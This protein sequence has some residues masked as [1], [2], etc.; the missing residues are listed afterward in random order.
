MGPI[1]TAN[2]QMEQSIPRQEEVVAAHLIVKA[3][4]SGD[5]VHYDLVKQTGQNGLPNAPTF[6]RE[7]HPHTEGYQFQPEN[8]VV[9]NKETSA[10]PADHAQGN[11]GSWGDPKPL[12]GLPD[13]VQSYAGDGTQWLAEQHMPMDDDTL[14]AQTSTS[15]QHQHQEAG[16]Q[17]QQTHQASPDQSSILL[18]RQS[19]DESMLPKPLSWKKGDEH[20]PEIAL[21]QAKQDFAQW[22]SGAHAHP[23]YVEHMQQLAA[24]AQE[25]AWPNTGD[26]SGAGMHPQDKELQQQAA[27]DPEA[28]HLNA[29]NQEVSDTRHVAEHQASKSSTAVST[30]RHQGYQDSNGVNTRSLGNPLQQLAGLNAGTAAGVYKGYIGSNGKGDEIDQLQQQVV[31]NSGMPAKTYV[32]YKDG[33]GFAYVDQ[34]PVRQGS[35]QYTSLGS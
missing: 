4:G 33:N 13:K 18:H 24:A 9:I 17:A 15:S 20:H 7:A 31:A 23:D 27:A 28:A 29:G 30:D 3:A 22:L 26:Q 10:E 5:T 1:A 21:N 6:T 25:A 12:G 32:G 8:I 34:M 2:Q 14:T 11:I 16:V 19:W 35:L